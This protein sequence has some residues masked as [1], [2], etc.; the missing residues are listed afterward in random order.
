MAM[1]ILLV[2][3]VLSRGVGASI[4]GTGI[5]LETFC[6]NF[7]RVSIGVSGSILGALGSGVDLMGP[8]LSGAI[9]AFFEVPAFGDP[10]CFRFGSFF[11]FSV[12]L[13][14]CLSSFAFLFVAFLV[15][16]GS[17]SSSE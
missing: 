11:L 17:T 12:S 13:E 1:S 9:L 14:A 8:V 5:L 4:L 16:L 3:R 2:S 6:T 15:G 10:W 7:A